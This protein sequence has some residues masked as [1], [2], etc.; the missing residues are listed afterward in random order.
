MGEVFFSFGEIVVNGSRC[1]RVSDDNH[2]IS[3]W[4]GLTIENNQKDINL[5]IKEL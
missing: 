3:V 4:R 5:H 1:T 2:D